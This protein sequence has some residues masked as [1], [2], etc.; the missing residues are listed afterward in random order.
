YTWQPTPDVRTWAQLVAHMTDDANN[1]CWQVAGLSAA[2]ARIETGTPPG[3]PAPVA[4][5][6]KDDLVKAITAAVD[7]CNKAV[8]A[9]TPDD[10]RQAVGRGSRINR[11]ITTTAHANEHYGNMVVYFRLRGLV[12]PSTADRGRGRGGH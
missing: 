10:M 8:A 1:S 2:P 5:M 7:V 6:K 3:S 11:L 9:T 12:P 4:T